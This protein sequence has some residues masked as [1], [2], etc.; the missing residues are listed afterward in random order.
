MADQESPLVMDEYDGPVV[1][2]WAC[3]ILVAAP[4]GNDGLA[5]PVFKVRT[6]ATDRLREYNSVKQTTYW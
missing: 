3:N 4:L 5:A 2:C 6:P 1:T